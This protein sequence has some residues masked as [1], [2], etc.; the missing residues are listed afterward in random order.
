[1]YYDYDNWWCA[2][3]EGLGGVWYGEWFDYSWEEFYGIYYYESEDASI[4]A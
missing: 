4:F 3:E 1:M 2:G